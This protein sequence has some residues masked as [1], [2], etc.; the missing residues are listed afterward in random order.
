MLSAI[1]VQLAHAQPAYSE[2]LSVYIAGSDALWYFTFGGLNGSSHLSALESTPGLSWYNVTAVSTAGW[3]SDFQVFGPRGYNLLPVPYLTPQGMFLAVGSDSYAHA[4]AAASAL[5]SYLLTDF[6][7]YLNGTGTY[8]FYSPVSFTTLVS[9]TLLKLLPTGEHGFSNAISASSFITTASPFIV[10]EGVSSSSGFQHSLVVGSIATSAVSSTGTP[11]VLSYFGATVSH[12]NA[13]SQSSSSVVQIKALDGIMQSSDPATLSTD[14]RSFTSTYT[15]NVAPGKSISRVNATLVQ[16]PAT[17]LATRAVDVGVLRTGDNLAVTLAFTN[18]SPAYTITNITYTDGWWNGSGDFK[19]LGGNDSLTSTSLTVGASTTPVYR[20]EYTGSATGP[21]TIPA[22]AVRYQYQANGKTFTG[23]TQLNPITLSL[24]VDEPVVYAI[25]SP[26]GSLGKPAG[27]TQTMNV[28]VFNVGTSPAISVVVAG[29]SIAGLAPKSG[30]SPGGTATVSVPL[31]VGALGSVNATTSYTVTYQDPNGNALQAETNVVSVIFSHV[32]IITG[33]PVL[34]LGA[35][36]SPLSSTA[37]NVTISFVA[38]NFGLANATSFRA[39]GELPSWLGCGAVSGTGIACSGNQVVIT[40]GQINKST[41]LRSF[42]SY[43]VTSPVNF[44]LS[45]LTFHWLSSGQN[46]S[47]ESNLAAVPAGMKLTKSFT[48]SQLFMG[49]ASTVAAAAFNSG[50]LPFYNAT[51]TTTADSFD[52]VTSSTPLTTTSATIAPGGNVTIDYPVSMLQS[53]GNMTGTPTDATF[54]F[55][56]TSF[57]LHGAKPRVQ[58]YQPLSVSIATS[59]VTPEE[60]KSFNITVEI[61]NP[62]GVS[63]NDVLF[64][65]PLPA[66]LTLSDLQNANATSR[67]LTVSVPSL[68]PGANATASASAVAGSGITVPF[69]GAKLT[70]SYSGSTVS[71]VV[72]TSSGIAIAENVVTRY[73]IPIAIILVVMVGVAFYVRRLASS[74]PASP[75]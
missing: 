35:T 15:L 12:L 29:H 54:F 25:V 62:S 26:I 63:V 17:L 2:K 41:T 27:S 23:T 24:G 46:V 66:G 69:S 45:P 40:Y 8:T 19:F 10:L 11:T 31:S 43:N 65:L 47:G 60:G 72:P 71:G 3:H 7:S 14:T 53:Y 57:S 1:P 68:G 34:T 42:M 48:P 32:A 61:N 50:Q 18:I 38:S 58:V 5:D 64:T 59:P 37:T 36:L 4:S 56:G 75:K 55:G 44:I 20:L 74:G 9:S 28:T 16:Q 51:V 33:F 6:V 52:R 67:I 39:V 49:M 73:L 21:L 13:S 30:G 22:S 70:F